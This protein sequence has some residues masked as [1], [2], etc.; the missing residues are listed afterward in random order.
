MSVSPFR[1]HMIIVAAVVLV[2]SQCLAIDDL[3]HSA[4]V[5]ELS[6]NER[7]TP[8]ES[9][10][11]GSPAISPLGTKG[12]IGADEAAQVMRTKAFLLRLGYD[13]GR[14]DQRITAKFRAA[15]FQ[16]QKANKLPPSGML[17]DAT[18]KNLESRFR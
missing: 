5:I 11:P 6:R 13:V 4:R 3:V 14:L 1:L 16:F 2:S 7:S 15:I 17:D 10:L 9:V 12:S 8:R 18:L